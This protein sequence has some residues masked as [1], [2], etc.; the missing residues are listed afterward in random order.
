[1]KVYTFGD[2]EKPAVLLLPGTCCHWESNF[3]Q[4]IP[5]TEIHIFYAL[6]MGEKHRARYL[7]HFARPVIHE[8]DLQHEELLVRFPERWAALVREIITKGGTTQ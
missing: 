6:K 3:G 1:M 8:L 7:Q 4:I 2:A 5:G